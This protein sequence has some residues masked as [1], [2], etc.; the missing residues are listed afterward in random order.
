MRTTFSI[1]DFIIDEDRLPAVSGL[2]TLIQQSTG[3]ESLPG[4][5]RSRLPGQLLWIVTTPPRA[6]KS[7]SAH[8]SVGSTTES[9]PPPPPSWS[10]ASIAPA[11]KIIMPKQASSRARFRESSQIGPILRLH[12]T[13]RARGLT[14]GLTQL[15]EYPQEE[16]AASTHLQFPSLSEQR[17]VWAIGKEQRRILICLDW[18]RPIVIHLDNEVPG[19]CDRLVCFEINYI[20]LL[21]LEP[22]SSSSEPMYRRLGYAR[23]HRESSFFAEAEEMEIWLA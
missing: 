23:T 6:H 8:I 17:N 5:W 2:A 19:E 10:W 7:A 11:R 1:R 22:I 9:R 15:A 13:G 4:L 14:R 18:R 21:L 20:G 12:L 16:R 3:E